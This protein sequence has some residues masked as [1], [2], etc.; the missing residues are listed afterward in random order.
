MVAYAENSFHI[1]GMFL[2]EKFQ[3]FN[4]EYLRLIL[5]TL[6]WK[7]AGPQSTTLGIYTG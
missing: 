4:A 5:K 2:N 3:G 1:M 7:L 6:R